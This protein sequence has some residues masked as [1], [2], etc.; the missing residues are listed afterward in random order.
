MYIITECFSV[1]AFCASNTSLE[2]FVFL[3]LIFLFTITSVVLVKVA[4]PA[5]V[6]HG[7]TAGNNLTPLDSTA[8]PAKSMLIKLQRW[9]DSYT[10]LCSFVYFLKEIEYISISLLR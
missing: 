7:R 8:P 2:C 10:I 5:I 1:L 4:I 3:V 9:V 6:A